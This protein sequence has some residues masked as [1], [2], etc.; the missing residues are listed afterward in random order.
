[1][2]DDS[3]NARITDFGL[4][5]FTQNPD[6]HKS[7]PDIDGHTARWCAPELFLTNQPA[8]KE[9]DIF[10]FGMVMIEVGGDKLVPPRLSHSLM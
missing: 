8:S 3:G 2:V 9:S 7:A 4:A 6:S 5:T 1:M 10:S